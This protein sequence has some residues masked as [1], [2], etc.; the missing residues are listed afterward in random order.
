MTD[1]KIVISNS[2]FWTFVAHLEP[3]SKMRLDGKVYQITGDQEEYF[4]FSKTTGGT[5]LHQTLRDDSRLMFEFIFEWRGVWEGRIYFRDDEF[6]SEEL[7]HMTDFWNQLE[8][9]LMDLIIAANPEYKF[10]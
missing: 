8:V 5:D 6:W 7:S 4:Y 3:K 9:K 10:K 2:P 1:N